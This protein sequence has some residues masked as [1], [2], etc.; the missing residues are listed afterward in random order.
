MTVVPLS[1]LP[2]LVTLR[3]AKW[4]SSS[5]ST[6]PTQT[7]TPVEGEE[8]DVSVS[9]VEGEAPRPND[10]GRAVA[11][12]WSITEADETLPEAAEHVQPVDV[13]RAHQQSLDQAQA[14]GREA[15]PDCKA[16]PLPP[17]P[18]NTASQAVRDDSSSAVSTQQPDPNDIGSMEDMMRLRAAS[19]PWHPANPKGRVMVDLEYYTLSGPYATVVPAVVPKEP[20][21][22][23][24]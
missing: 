4:Q 19:Q 24:S 2:T 22:E 8:K 21:L 17:Q 18:S 16:T 12:S 5:C 11:P 6:Q 3:S 14:A 1:V 15:C 23:D 10:I 13:Q 7:A 20:T 9:S